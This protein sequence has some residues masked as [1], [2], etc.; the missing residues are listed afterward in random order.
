MTKAQFGMIGLGTMGRNFLLNVA[1]KGFSG[2]GYDL[3]AEKR[4]LLL[5]EGKDFELQTGETLDEFLAK[6]GSPR[7]IMI[8]V[9]AQVVDIVINDLLTKLDA[10]DIVIDGGNSHFPE[11]ERREKTLAEK[12]IEFLGVGVS[13]GEEGARHGA[14][15]MI[16][17]KREV[18][19]HVEPILEAA[20]AKVNGEACAAFVGKGSAGHFVKMV[21]NGIEYGLM[22][23]LAETY[24]FM[25]R[26][27]K[28]DYDEMSKTFGDWNNAELNSFLV[29]IT[30]EVLKKTDVETGKP[31]VEMVLDKAAQKGTGKWTSQAAMDFGVP[32]PTIDSAVSMRQISAQKEARVLI[33][34]K[35]G[36]GELAITNPPTADGKT[37]SSEHEHD[38]AKAEREKRAAET[39]VSEHHKENLDAQNVG[40][41]K[42]VA[43]DEERNSAVREDVSRD[44][45]AFLELLKHTL[46]SSFIVTYAQG[47]SLL[48]TVSKEKEYELHLSEI[49]K[50]WRGGCI[51]RSAL[52][53]EMR[54]AYDKNPDLAN[55]ILDDKFAEILSKNRDFWCKINNE[56]A[57]SQV[58]SLCLSSALS[59]FDAFR[60]ER[61]PANLIQAQRDFFGAHTYQRTDKEGTFHT[62]DWDK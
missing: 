43:S 39:T 18:Y 7:K 36:K 28:M 60:S 27:L 40:D 31:L 4:R 49:A 59:Y 47:M 13:G 9:P 55:L 48:Q 26:V 1:E 41:K 51:I 12:N 56:F 54:A 46:L 8:L 16:G 3:D 25:F 42:E 35:Y 10:G 37:V 45:S 14:S 44:K 30:A 57:M 24:D 38:A 53:E 61:L 32:I 19:A 11:T 20:S 62:P 33:A 15:I 29:E 34:E 58:P 5:E 21:H 17:G 50:I 2:V 52:L 23:I 6:L 22:Q